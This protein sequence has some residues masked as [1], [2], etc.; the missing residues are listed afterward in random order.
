M[1]RLILFNALYV[2][3]SAYAMARGGTPERLG[4]AILIAD[5][6]LS[7]WVIAPMQSR[8]LGV[9]WAMFAVDLGAFVALYVLSLFSGR[10][11]PMWMSA[12]QGVVA[13][14]HL[15][16]LL[17]DIVPWA[18]GNAIALWAYVLLLMLVA[19]TW[20]HRAR[21]RRYGADPAWRTQLPQS[22]LMGECVGEAG[23]GDR[24]SREPRLSLSGET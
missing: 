10:Y 17:P 13:V 23:A 8:Y 18:Y 16:G 11:W 1:L 20:R 6:E 2:S 7:H 4:A 12:L 21:L 9:E 3:S 15:S 5:F 22:Y 14:S 19:G 24:P